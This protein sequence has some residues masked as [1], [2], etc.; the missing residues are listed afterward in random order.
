MREEGEDC[1][2]T[3]NQDSESKS[4]NREDDR[5]TSSIRL[6]LGMH[7]CRTRKINSTDVTSRSFFL[8]E[9]PERLLHSRHTRLLLAKRSQ[10][11]GK[12]TDP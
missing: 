7:A 4:K 11:T 6:E 8:E 12:D 9:S 5:E 10:D 3:P 1:Y 2:L